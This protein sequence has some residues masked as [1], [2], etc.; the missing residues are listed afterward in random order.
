MASPAAVWAA[1]VERHPPGAIEFYGTLLVQLVFFWLPSA[2]Y[3]ALDP[4]LPSFSASHKLQPAPKQPSSSEIRHCFLVTLR[5]QLLVVAI[6]FVPYYLSLPSPLRV[7]STLPSLGEFLAHIAASSFL[8]E[9]LFY[10]S[11]RLMHMPTLYRRIHKMHHHF[12]APV[13]LASQYAHPIEHIVSNAAPIALPL[14]LLN[15]HVVTGWAFLAGVLFETATVH[16][17]YDFFAGLAESHDE[18][19]RRFTVNF[20]VLGVLDRMHGTYGAIPK[21]KGE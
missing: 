12:T 11:H 5:N 13:S 4:L 21:G 15:A 14:A 6:T 16:S 8:R 1:L 17:G 10:Y 9:A 3:I 18:H 7:S 20:G 2:L 19:H